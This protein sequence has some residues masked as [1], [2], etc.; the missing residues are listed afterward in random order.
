MAGRPLLS[1]HAN[2]HGPFRFLVDPLATMTR[3]DMALVDELRLRPPST[4]GGQA[5][6][7]YRV[8]CRWQASPCGTL[9]GSDAAGG[10]DVSVGGCAHAG[11]A[12]LGSFVVIIDAANRRVQFVPQRR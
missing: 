8:G 3:L 2:G 7:V 12:W 1:V 9:G 5:P 6:A 11:T 10:A 4:A